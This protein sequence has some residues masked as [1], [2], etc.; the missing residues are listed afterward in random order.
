MP[1]LQDETLVST[2]TLHLESNALCLQLLARMLDR[3]KCVQEAACSAFAGLEENAKGLLIPDLPKIFETFAAALSLYQT[4]NVTILYDA[5]GTLA[6]VLGPALLESWPSH[7]SQA[8][9]QPFFQKWR[10]LEPTDYQTPALCECMGFLAQAIG[11]A[12]APMGS[13][14]VEKC[15]YL[16]KSILQKVHGEELDRV[17]TDVI[18]CS[19][20]LI[21]YMA[22]DMR[23]TL[24]VA[25]THQPILPLLEACCTVSMPWKAK[26]NVCPAVESRDGAIQLR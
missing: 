3:S 24:V 1:S 6:N 14:L 16:V 23:D 25:L 20:D 2:H 22:E 5:I 9:L 18:E 7:Y 11:P 15:Y 13:V 19:L 4:R 12:L 10:Q 26:N 17:Q 8:F 21:S